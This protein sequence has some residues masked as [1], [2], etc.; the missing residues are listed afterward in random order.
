MTSAALITLLQRLA[1]VAGAGAEVEHDLWLQLY[2][3][4][5]LEQAIAD[6]CRDCGRGVVATRRAIE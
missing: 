2:E 4:E 6:F 1:R 5:S 3:V